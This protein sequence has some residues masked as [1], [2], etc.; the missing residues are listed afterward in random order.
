ME[1]FHLPIGAINFIHH[2]RRGS[3]QIKIEL[4]GQPFLNNFQMQQPKEATTETKPKG[5]GCFCFIMERG[6]V[7]P[8]FGQTIPQFFKIISDNGVQPTPYHGNGGFKTGQRGCRRPTIIR[9]RIP[10]VTVCNGFDC[11]VNEPHF[12]RTKAFH[13]RHPWSEHAHLIHLMHCTR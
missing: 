6:I 1:F 12:S 13:S 9:D 7:Q 5:C 8:Q 10:H 2:G 3:D 11:R 4:A